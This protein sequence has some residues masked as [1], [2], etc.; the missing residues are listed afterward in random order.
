M[1]ASRIESDNPL[2]RPRMLT[3]TVSA[4]NTAEKVMSERRRFRSTFRNA[5]RTRG[6]MEMSFKACVQHLRRQG[7]IPKF[8]T[9]QFANANVICNEQ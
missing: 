8:N 5:I 6:V 9:C 7:L 3:I 1:V 4:K 2:T